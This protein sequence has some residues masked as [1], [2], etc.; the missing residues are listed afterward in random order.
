MPQSD[1]N[2]PYWQYIGDR[3]THFTRRLNSFLSDYSFIESMNSLDP[4]DSS[5]HLNSLT[6]PHHS[7]ISSSPLSSSSFDSPSVALGDDNEHPEYYTNDNNNDNP[8]RVNSDQTNWFNISPF[9]Y[10]SNGFLSS[11][12]STTTRPTSSL[13]FSTPSSFG[14]F[15]TSQ[16]NSFDS[17]IF[18]KIIANPSD[19]VKNSSSLDILE[20]ALNPNPG[21]GQVQPPILELSP[22]LVPH[23][24]DKS[25]HGDDE[26]ILGQFHPTTASVIPPI[27][28]SKS[29]DQ[30]N[31]I[32]IF[33]SS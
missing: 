19:S 33:I 17:N 3:I 16:T 11:P 2:A 15:I 5:S 1:Q 22:S 21:F 12:S 26:D 24:I 8:I 25:K 13:H 32:L 20:D 31:T 23:S 14:E 9:S 10:Q 6:T 30:L 29:N 28:V 18:G 7:K 4:I 27:H